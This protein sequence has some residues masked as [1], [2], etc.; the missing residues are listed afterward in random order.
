MQ[1]TL[2]NF[3]KDGCAIVP[4]CNYNMDPKRLDKGQVVGKLYPVTLEGP[5]VSE[6]TLEPADVRALNAT[7]SSSDN[8]NHWEKLCKGLKVTILMDHVMMGYV[9]DG[10]LGD[11]FLVDGFT[12]AN[13]SQSQSPSQSLIHLS[14]I[15]NNTISKH[16]PKCITYIVQYKVYNYTNFLYQLYCVCIYM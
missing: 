13:G 8:E 2:L 1:S 7:E 11:G 5:E 16:K 12:H 15:I 4:V 3:D 9:V 10:F 14:Q 6:R